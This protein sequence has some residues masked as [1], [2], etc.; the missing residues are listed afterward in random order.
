MVGSGYPR[1][2]HLNGPEYGYYNLAVFFDSC[3]FNCLFCRNWHYREKTLKGSPS[4]SGD[5]AAAVGSRTSCICYFGGDPAPQFPFS[6]CVSR[7]AREKNKG[8]IVRICWENNGSMSG[9]F[10]DEMVVLAVES[11]GCIKLDL[12][13]W[14]K[15]LHAALTGV[16]NE[17][18]LENFQRAAG[19][20]IQRP[21]PPLL[22]ASALLVPGHI[23]EQEVNHIARFIR[24]LSPDI[25]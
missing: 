1:Y 9:R 2:A 10:L 20:I 6:L 5:L 8:S 22:I 3:T 24:F 4:R 11:G 15:D 13:A 12:K 23:E 25:S 21:S 18:T 7:T 14:N 17:M 19:K 16:T